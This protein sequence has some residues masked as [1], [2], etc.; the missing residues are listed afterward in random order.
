M[1]FLIPTF[2]RKVKSL[3]TL[4]RSEIKSPLLRKPIF[5]ILRNLGFKLHLKLV[6]RDDLLSNKDNYSIKEFGSEE[7]VTANEAYISEKT[8]KKIKEEFF[9]F[10]V[11]LD[12]PFVCEVPDAELVGSTA[13]GFDRNGNIITETIVP[14]FFKEGYLEQNV[15]IRALALKNFSRPS[16]IQLDTAC[17]LVYPWAK[18]YWHWIVDGLT[19]IEGL[20]AYQEQTGIKPTLIIESNLTSWQSESLKLLGYEPDECIRWNELRV[21]VKKLLV[22]SFRRYWGYY[23]K[24][25]KT[26]NQVVSP[27]ACRWLRQRILSN[28]PVVAS[29]QLNFSSKIFISRRK[30]LQRRI[31]NEDEVIEALAPF[32]FVAYALEELSFSEQVRLFSQADMVVAPHGAGLTNMIFSENLAVIEL[33]GSYV[34]SFYIPGFALANLSRGLGFRYGCLMGQSYPQDS[35]QIHTDLIVDITELR[36]LV[37]KM[38]NV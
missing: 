25:Y 7:L 28:L 38:H 30:A 6:I 20:E 11:K 36:D 37:A 3:I 9:S 12:R 33:F 34:P 32:G 15:S 10:T 18:N 19:R 22:P 14:F 16:A 29:E 13:T 24:T 17:S 1:V 35:R 26:Y 31:I 21:Q 2:N 4:Y 23:N 27:M 5:F 8:P